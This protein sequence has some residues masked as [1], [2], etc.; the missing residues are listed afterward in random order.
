MQDGV[1]EVE[2]QEAVSRLK[3]ALI[4]LFDA[5][6]ADPQRPQDVARRLGVN[7]TLT[8]SISRFLETPGAIES[9]SFVPGAGSIARVAGAFPDSPRIVEAK[10]RVNAAAIDFDAMIEKHAGDR[11]TLELILDNMARHEGDALELSRRLMFRGQSGISGVQAKARLSTWFIAPSPDDPT[12]LDLATLRG[13]I[14]IRRLR[15]NVEWPIFKTRAWGGTDDQLDRSGWQPIDPDSPPEAPLMREF[16]RGEL[17]VVGAEA[18]PEGLDFVLRSGPV[19]NMGSFDCF[20][21]EMMRHAVSRYA[22]TK[23]ETG[24]LGNAITTPCETLVFDV[25]YHKSLRE[26]A[27]AEPIIFGEIFAQR[28]PTPSGTDGRVLPIRPGLVEIA[29]TP[30]AVATALVP[31]YSEM[32]Q[33]TCARCRWDL[34]D[35]AG[36]RLEMQ[37]P[38]LH[39]QIVLRFA[40]P[41]R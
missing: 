15:P 2:C 24:E 5:G 40:L 13:Y 9:L 23:D 22:Q 39:S 26:V 34:K 25:L 33:F 28:Q 36:L 18:T 37:Y 35:F 14:R 19:G 7:K 32:V 8:W 31:R 29:G 6:Q 30:P 1:F 21:G 38:P 12:Q 10:L 11:S 41:R 16:C 20:T 27:R 4:E 3:S 17:P